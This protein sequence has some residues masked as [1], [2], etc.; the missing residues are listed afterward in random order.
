MRSG[1]RANGPQIVRSSTFIWPADH[2]WCVAHDV[3]PHY[4]GI[5]ASSAAVA[6]LL[7]QPDLDVVPADPRVEQPYYR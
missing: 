4:A 7:A 5:G 1:L 3:D 6:D 2:A